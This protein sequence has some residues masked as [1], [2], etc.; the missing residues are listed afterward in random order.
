MDKEV[1]SLIDELKSHNNQAKKEAKIAER[2]AKITTLEIDIQT[3]MFEEIIDNTKE[4]TT[5]IE[6]K[7]KKYGDTPYVKTH[8]TKLIVQ[9]KEAIVNAK[10]TLSLLPKKK[11]PN[12][13]KENVK[14]NEN[15]NVKEKEK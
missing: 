8:T 6:E 4:I 1:G 11:E 12:E 13:H 15:V 10:E 2:H 7:R 14:E 5:I 9:L 3:L